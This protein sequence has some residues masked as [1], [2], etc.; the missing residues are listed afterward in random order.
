MKITFAFL[1]GLLASSQ[2]WALTSY[3]ADTTVEVQLYTNGTVEFFGPSAPVPPNKNPNKADTII[4]KFEQKAQNETKI[5]SK[6]EDSGKSHGNA[7]ITV[8]KNANLRFQ[9][10]TGN[11]SMTDIIGKVKGRVESGSVTITRGSGKMEINTDKGDISVMESEASGFVMTRSGNIT[12][13]DVQGQLTGISQNGKVIV[14]TT[15]SYFTGRK[16]SRFLMNYDQADIDIAAAPEGG[17]FSLTKGNIS[18]QNAQ[19]SIIMRTEE[20]DLSIAPA[21]AG[22]RAMTRKGKVSLQMATNANSSEPIIIEAQN[23]DVDL[24]VPNNFS[25]NFII[26]LIQTQNLKTTNVI[27]SFLDLGKTIPQ[28]LIDAKTKEVLSRET[29]II[30]SIRNGKRPVRI[31]VVNGNVN[32]KKA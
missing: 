21:S 24:I 8:E 30:Q 11:V 16:A 26:T 25:G 6:K 18:V 29:Q 13:Q 17:E 3:P 14:K 32:I 28:E 22:V 15:N 9:T 20:G 2:S 7:Q 1:L 27:T 31:R 19:Q 5:L 4:R 10:A 12:L 23:G